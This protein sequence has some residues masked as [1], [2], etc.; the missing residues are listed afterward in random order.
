[1]WT[2]TPTATNT[3][4]PTATGQ[5]TATITPTRPPSTVTPAPT[6]S[7]TPAPVVPEPASLTLLASGLTALAG[8][9]ALRR[10]R[11]GK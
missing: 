10:G 8:Y 5:P 1:T 4:P 7:P 9:A 3:P 11:G 2:P 6:V